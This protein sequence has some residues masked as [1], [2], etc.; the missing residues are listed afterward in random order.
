MLALCIAML[1]STCT[2]GDG[3]LNLNGVLVAKGER[4]EIELCPGFIHYV[5]TLE[6]ASRSRTFETAR[7]SGSSDRSSGSAPRRR[8]RAPTRPRAR[9]PRSRLKLTASNI[10]EV[11]QSWGLLR[12][13]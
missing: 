8:H 5:A 2:D 1:A 6:E 3:D 13:L 12:A 9:R 7:S 10:F 4:P 11:I